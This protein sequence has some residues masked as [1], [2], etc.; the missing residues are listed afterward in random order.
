[1]LFGDEIVLVARHESEHRLRVVAMIGDVIAPQRSAMGKAILAHVSVQRRNE[2]LE[3]ALGAGAGAGAARVADELAEELAL[4]ASEGFARDEEIFAVGLRCVAA[5]VLGP[6]GEAQGAI[7]IA[8]PSSR[9]SREL[10][11]GCVPALLDGARRVS[12]GGVR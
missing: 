4:A 3:S 5:P 10:A 7:S 11:D 6:G 9:F 2:I 8:G 1:M 12:A